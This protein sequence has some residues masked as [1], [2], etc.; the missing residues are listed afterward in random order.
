MVMVVFRCIADVESDVAVCAENRSSW[1]HCMR[2]D[3]RCNTQPEVV[4]ASIS[5][6]HYGAHQ[7]NPGALLLANHRALPLILQM[8][9]W[10]CAGVVCSVQ[11]LIPAWLHATVY[12]VGALQYY[13]CLCQ[14]LGS[15]LRFVCSVLFLQLG[16]THRSSRYC[17]DHSGGR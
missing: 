5:V 3:T 15:V 4:L 13:A 11:D 10:G 16:H 7:R 6:E 1:P 9:A 14:C 12:C 2:V 17:L 8:L